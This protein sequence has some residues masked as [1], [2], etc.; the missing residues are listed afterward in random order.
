MSM[1]PMLDDLAST[2]VAVMFSTPCGS[3]SLNGRPGSRQARGHDDAGVG[4]DD[5]LLEGGRH[6][7]E[8]AG[9]A[10][11]EGVVE[12]VVAE[13]CLL[14]GGEVVGVERRVARGGPDLAGRDLDDDGGARLGADAR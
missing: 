10:G 4:G 2:P 6:R 3:L 1:V 9:R 5:L 14:G 13:R 8:L 12:G 7:H 11:L